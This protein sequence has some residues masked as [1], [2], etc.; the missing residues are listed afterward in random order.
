MELEGVQAGAVPAADDA[1]YGGEPPA[2]KRQRYEEEPALQ[3]EET[4]AE[5]VGHQ[6][7]NHE[8][9]GSEATT[10]TSYAYVDYSGAE[11]VLETSATPLVEAEQAVEDASALPLL[12]ALPPP[13][14]WHIA[15][16]ESSFQQLYVADEFERQRTNN[17]LKLARWYSTLA[18][19]LLFSH[20]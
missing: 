19:S 15:A 3:G 6:Q 12:P 17:F 7:H 4:T 9:G 1:M 14:P 10:A 5:Q 20:C 11:A 8:M 16:E 2:S 18:H 13:H